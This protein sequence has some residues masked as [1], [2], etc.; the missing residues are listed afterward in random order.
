M[1]AK[2]RQI[3]GFVLWLGAVATLV[4]AW[5][6][7]A[8]QPQRGAAPARRTSTGTATPLDASVLRVNRVQ[9]DPG[10]RSFWHSH[11]RG[12]IWYIEDGRGLIQERGGRIVELRPGDEPVWTPPNIEHWHGA[13]PNEKGTYVAIAC[14]GDDYVNWLDEE[15]SDPVYKGRTV[16]R[17]QATAN[18]LHSMKR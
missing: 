15:V 18:D 1:V 3:I 12:Q 7:Q 14:C 9:R 4:A 17:K 6:V 13:A 8:Q 5:T 2:A 11:P 10:S 16:P